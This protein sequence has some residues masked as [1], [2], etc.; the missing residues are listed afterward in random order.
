MRAEGRA[1]CNTRWGMLA[2]H[3][4]EYQAEG[5]DGATWKN[6]IFFFH[7]FFI[8]LIQFGPWPVFVASQFEH[9]II[10][11]YKYYL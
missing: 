8:L 1:G 5:S 2:G 11:F 4:D 7:F 9:A 6:R 10:T 3:E